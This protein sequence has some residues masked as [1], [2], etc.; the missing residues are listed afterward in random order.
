[1]LHAIMARLAHMSVDIAGKL[2]H[3]ALHAGHLVDAMIE[4]YKLF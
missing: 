3:D 2:F 4:R 1:M